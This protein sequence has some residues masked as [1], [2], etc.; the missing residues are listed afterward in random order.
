MTNVLRVFVVTLMYVFPL[1]AIAQPV[2]DQSNIGASVVKSIVD[3][4]QACMQTFQAG[5]SGMLEY[6]E[7]DIETQN[8]PYPL[9]CKILD[10]MPDGVELASQVKEVPAN[11]SRT[12]VRVDFDL[13]TSVLAGQTYTLKIEANCVNGPGYSDFWYASVTNAYANGRAYHAT[14]T[15]ITPESELNDFYFQ[16]YVNTGEGIRTTPAPATR[17]IYDRE[18]QCIQLMKPGQSP[19]HMRLYSLQG[20]LWDSFW[21]AGDGHVDVSALPPGWVFVVIEQEQTVSAT[22]LLIAPR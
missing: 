16:T 14:G 18:N 3:N 4:S 7:L 8:C 20:Q 2:L 12:M 5:L 17:V 10:G 21:L 15:I 1:G 11:T 6:V 22:R 19:A 13:P 9:V